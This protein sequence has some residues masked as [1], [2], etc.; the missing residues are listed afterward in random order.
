MEERKKKS[1]LCDD[2]LDFAVNIV[3]HFG[4]R[5]GASPLNQPVSPRPLWLSPPFAQSD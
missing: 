5:F 1:A 4:G 2:L 3:P